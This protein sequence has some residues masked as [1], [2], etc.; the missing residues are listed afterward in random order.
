[1]VEIRFGGNKTKT[2]NLN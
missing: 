2:Q 1:V